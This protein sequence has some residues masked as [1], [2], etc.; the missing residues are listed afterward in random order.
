MKGFR[1]LRN[2]TAFR[3]SIYHSLGTLPFVELVVSKFVRMKSSLTVSAQ[4]V[5]PFVICIIFHPVAF[6]KRSIYMYI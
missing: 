1:E 4:Y 5:N 3:A 2:Y 6:K